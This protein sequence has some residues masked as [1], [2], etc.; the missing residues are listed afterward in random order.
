MN[1]DYHVS[2]DFIEGEVKRFYNWIGV[3]TDVLPE[4]EIDV[5]G[6]TASSGHFDPREDQWKSVIF[7]EFDH[8]NHRLV[9][10]NLSSLSFK[11]IE[12]RKTEVH[13][14]SHTYFRDNF[15]VPELEYDFR[16]MW[17]LMTEGMLT[18]WLKDL[19]HETLNQIF[20]LSEDDFRVN[21]DFN[22]DLLLRQA[23]YVQ[24][25]YGE[26][27]YERFFE[28]AGLKGI[29]ESLVRIMAESTSATT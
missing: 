14:A 4:V 10:G 9:E 28:A 20:Q 27:A 17:E 15:D 19:D 18:E 1:T 11:G 22:R 21:P 25:E 3:D 23:D 12:E 7:P 29:D 6:E 26:E 16:D 8:K 2:E 24:E 13:E 5:V